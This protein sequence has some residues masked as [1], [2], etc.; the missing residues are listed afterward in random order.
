M[1]LRQHEARVNAL[2]L[3]SEGSPG[4]RAWAP[5]TFALTSA[6]H[7]VYNDTVVLQTETA[8]RDKACLHTRLAQQEPWQVLG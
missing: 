1:G 7:C 4:E 6:L 2:M 8:L 5:M 3:K